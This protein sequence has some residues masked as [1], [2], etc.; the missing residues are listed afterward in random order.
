VGSAGHSARVQKHKRLQ[1]RC[2]CSK[3]G[4]EKRG[5]NLNIA[6]AEFGGGPGSDVVV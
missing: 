3:V 4:A 2:V 1:V 5:V 6:Q